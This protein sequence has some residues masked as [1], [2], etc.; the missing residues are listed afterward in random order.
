MN[1]RVIFLVS[2]SV[3]AVIGSILITHYQNSLKPELSINSFVFSPYAPYNGDM[4]SIKF[5]IENTGKAPARD[6]TI[7][8]EDNGK[9]VNRETIK[10]LKENQKIPVEFNYEFTEAGAHILTVRIDC[11]NSLKEASRRN[12]RVSIRL[13]VKPHSQSAPLFK[14]KLGN[15]W[16]ST[17]YGGSS[18]VLHNGKVYVG[19]KN[20]CFF[21]INARTGKKEWVFKVKDAGIFPGIYTTPV[22]YD[23][24]V[25]FGSTGTN[26]LE[27][28][29]HVFAVNSETGKEKWEFV[30]D[31]D[32]LFITVSDGL[33]YA[34]SRRDTLYCLN[35]DLGNLLGKYTPQKQT[36]GILCGKIYVSNGIIVI[37]ESA[38]EHLRITALNVK[39]LK[40]IWEIMFKQNQPC[41][42]GSPIGYNNLLYVNGKYCIDIRTGK[43]IWTNKSIPDGFEALGKN[44]FVATPKGELYKLDLTNG[45]IIWKETVEPTES[46]MYICKDT[47]VFCSASGKIY[48][49]DGKYG[50]IISS[51]KTNSEIITKPMFDGKFV[52]AVAEDGYLYCFEKK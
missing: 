15:V 37:K 34:L 26:P 12:N 13:N 44:L 2:L 19:G 25:Y 9:T 36:N 28:K 51:F 16:Y 40:T 52:Y 22:F 5:E 6:F 35:P 49:L 21:C 30:T 29:G 4:E 7:C 31:S 33:L 47:L 20:N 45:S 18:P 32:I 42:T 48:L 43:I 17:N 50:E 10:E 27:E 46:P 38:S 41:N 8:L 39:T 14:T 23:G 24:N 3:G 11:G 1:K